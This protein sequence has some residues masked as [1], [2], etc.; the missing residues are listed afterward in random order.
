MVATADLQALR[1][2]VTAPSTGS[3]QQAD[4]TVVLHVTHCNLRLQMMELRFD[5]HVSSGPQLL[6]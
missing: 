3:Q 4:S 5:L 6:R 2:Y 1:D